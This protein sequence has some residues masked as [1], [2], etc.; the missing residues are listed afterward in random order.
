MRLAVLIRRTLL[1]FAVLGLILAPMARSAM[2]LSTPPDQM[3]A[4]DMSSAAAD[5]P[6]CPEGMSHAGMAL[7]ESGSADPAKNGCAKDCPM[8]VVCMAA[9][10]I[11]LPHGP[12]LS[13]PLAITESVPP[14]NDLHI[15]SLTRAPSPRPP[16][17]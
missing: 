14:K 16:N 4:D 7:P 11:G 5:M 8:M 15:S 6:C 9:S 2:A 10:L 17:A 3:T 13:F 1:T 12:A